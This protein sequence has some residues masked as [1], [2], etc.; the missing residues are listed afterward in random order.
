MALKLHLIFQEVFFYKLVVIVLGYLII[1]PF[2]YASPMQGTPG[3]VLCNLKV[4][5]RSGRQLNWLHALWRQ[6]MFVLVVS[7]IKFTFWINWLL[8]GKLVHDWL[9]R[10]V[11]IYRQ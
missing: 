10:S 3:K 6:I 7:T 1:T 8:K 9:S 2:L 11:V 5:S 4:V